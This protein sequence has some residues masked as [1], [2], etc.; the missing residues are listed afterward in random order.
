MTVVP[1][2]TPGC[3]NPEYKLVIK[4]SD[5]SPAIT[6]TSKTGFVTLN[7]L[8]PQV[9]HVVVAT[10]IC[11]DGKESPPTP[12]NLFIPQPP[13]NQTPT[14]TPTQTPT[15]AS[16]SPSPS[17]SG[18]G[19]GS[20]SPPPAGSGNSPPPP[21]NPIP[22]PPASPS[23]SPSPTPT[24]TPSPTPSLL[25]VL[26][27]NVNTA[28]SCLPELEVISSAQGDNDAYVDFSITCVNGADSGSGAKNFPLSYPSTSIRLPRLP[29][30][31][32]C[33]AKVKINNSGKVGPEKDLNFTT[34]ADCQ[35]TPAI[36]NDR[37]TPPD[38]VIV[39]V[40]PP[41]K[42][43]EVKEYLITLTPK[44]GGGKS[45]S[46]TAKPPDL[47]NVV[48]DG[49]VT[50]V[51]Y[52]AEIVG[53][54]KD[55]SKTP[56]GQSTIFQPL[57]SP[58][59]PVPK[60]S[61]P[62]PSPKPTPTPTPAPSPPPPTPPPP[63]TTIPPL[64]VSDKCK[65]V[66]CPS[67]KECLEGVCVG[68]SNDIQIVLTWPDYV[69]GDLDLHLID[70]DGCEIKWSDKNSC[71]NGY[72]DLDNRCESYPDFVTRAE[73]I[74]FRDTSTIKPG[75]YRLAVVLYNNCK[76]GYDPNTYD[77]TLTIRVRGVTTVY[78][79]TIGPYV[80]PY[81]PFLKE[82]EPFTNLGMKYGLLFEF[83]Y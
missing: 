20:S 60:P 27:F 77:F 17:P 75:K 50:G 80:A 23:P 2:E 49:F 9:V 72:L 1:P 30:G 21:K 44:G 69:D 36:I 47:N 29:A 65:G 10:A 5:G 73:N 3:K 33:S 41:P 25:K 51:E 78:N 26:D 11:P 71:S 37:P 48:I 82:G 19:N 18:G 79:R 52:D 55:N 74:F 45:I 6:V 22:N 32:K 24:P 42:G 63:A 53:T 15:P 8:K 76:S 28:G 83:D 31:T 54:C 4:P 62:P 61:P 40:V 43:C 46:A 58:P 59:P 34:D 56:P 68:S 67:G 81:T 70:P 16:P 39:D 38:K 35:D 7:S 12:P 13:N 14:P 57:P 64:V 66:T